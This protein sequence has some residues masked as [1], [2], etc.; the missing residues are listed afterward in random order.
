[1]DTKLLAQAL[2]KATSGFIVMAFLLFVP[3]GTIHWWQA[4]LLLG[5]LFVPM[6]IA[7]IVML[8]KA[9]DLLRKRLNT[10]EQESQQKLVI[11]LSAVMFC[12]SFVASAQGFRY[13]WTALPD[14][15]C[16]IGAAIFLASYLLIAGVMRENAFLSRT[17]EV[18]EGQKV[19]DMGM[20]GIVRHPMYAALFPLFLAMPITLGSP[21]GAVIMLFYIP[22]INIRIKNEEAVLTRELEGYTEYKQRVK[23]RL[24]PHIW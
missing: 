19:I 12:A 20:Y 18:Q 1:M 11:A 5:V 4:W 23:W 8:L 13:G 15:L 2:A 16:G 14:W 6:I 9:P 3:A 21:L 22:I 24:I 10:K 17:V 7:G